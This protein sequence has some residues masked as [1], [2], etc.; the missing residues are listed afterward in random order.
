MQSRTALFLSLAGALI[1]SACADR[2]AAVR[3]RIAAGVGAIR[4]IDT[5]EHLSPEAKRNKQQLSLFTS[6][7]YA[8]SDV[9][10][11]GLDKDTCERVLDDP[12]VPLERK[13]EL[14]APYW[15][16]VSNTAYVRSLSRAF[17]DLYGVNGISEA[18][19]RELSQKIQAANKPGW[20]EEVL[21]KR[22]GI[23]LSI[24]DTGLD[25]RELDPKLFRAVLRL[26][27]FLLFWNSFRSMEEIL[28][29]K[30]D[31]LADWELAI[32]TACA[33]AKE[34]GFVAIKSGVAYS[35]SI[36]F[37]RVERSEAEAL[38][39]RLR[40]DPGLVDR[41]DWR[42]KKPLQDYLFGRIAEGCARNGLPFQIHTGFFY[43]TWRDVSQADP[44]KL[45]PFIIR[46]P[47][48]RFVLMHCGYPYGEELLAMAKN[49]PNVTLDLC[50][51][52][53]ISPSFAARFLDEAIETVPRDKVLGFGGDYVL[54]EGSYGHAQLCREVVSKVLADK[55]LSG[56]WS[57]EEALDYARAILHDN[58]IRTFRLKL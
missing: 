50:W 25:G 29:V 40:R 49:L 28:G 43:D 47:N 1:F 3:K 46:H 26:D 36:Q 24:S 12:A 55:V 20:Y 38:F 7:H 44:T 32:D 22:A 19:Y 57:E 5:H 27:D 33:R 21:R 48:T 11:D 37:D 39:N 8:I 53:I 10:A 9:W 58:P 16:N 42:E 41:L 6:L 13:W 34:W 56:Y 35:R 17:R 45:A 23:D 4:L 31:S 54:P 30:V 2:D 18:T 52:Y 15:G 14:I 51:I